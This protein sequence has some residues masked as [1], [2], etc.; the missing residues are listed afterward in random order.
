MRRRNQSGRDERVGHRRV[1]R[2]TQTDDHDHR[3]DH[4]ANQDRDN[5]WVFGALFALGFK[6]EVTRRAVS[7]KGAGVSAALRESTKNFYF[8]KKKT[9]RE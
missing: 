5:R 4:Q 6:L 1:A 3:Q 8:T 9:A 2:R 7:A